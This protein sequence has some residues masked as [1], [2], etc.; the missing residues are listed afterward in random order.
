MNNVPIISRPSYS[1]DE[2]I[3]IITQL[4]SINGHKVTNNTPHAETSTDSSPNSP[5]P[6]VSSESS[7]SSENTSQSQNLTGS[8]PNDT[9]TDSDSTS[10]DTQSTTSQ[11][12]LASERSLRPRVPI[13]YNETLL[14]RL[15]GRPQ[16]RILNNLSIPW[17]GSSDEDTEETVEATQN[18]KREDKDTTSK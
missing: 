12:S 13:S 17:P 15:H 9:E 3:N 4:I 1:S 14:Q 6:T 7:I 11:T 8:S 18:E 10:D 16:V 5:A 2:V